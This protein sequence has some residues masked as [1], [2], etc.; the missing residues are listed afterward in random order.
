VKKAR[1]I[2]K[3]LW[4]SKMKK[5]VEKFTTFKWMHFDSDYF[6]LVLLNVEVQE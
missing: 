1:K 5:N 3:K 2:I 4:K 6:V